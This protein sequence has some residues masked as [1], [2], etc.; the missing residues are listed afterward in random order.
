MLRRKREKGGSREV[1][2][3]DGYTGGGPGLTLLRP[4]AET[5]GNSPVL[6]L[7]GQMSRKT[8][9][10]PFTIFIWGGFLSESSSWAHSL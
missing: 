8:S 4:G 2:V 3:M 6:L 10:G 1:L 7:E 5:L 9:A